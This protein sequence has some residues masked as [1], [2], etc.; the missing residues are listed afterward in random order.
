MSAYIVFAS[1][2]ERFIESATRDIAT[3]EMNHIYCFYFKDDKFYNRSKMNI[4]KLEVLSKKS[5]I[6]F[7]SIALKFD[8]YIGSWK[9]LEKAFDSMQL[10]G[11]TWLNISTMPRNMI[12]GMLHFLRAH[13]Y[14]V[15]YYPAKKHSEKPTTNP[16][17]PHIVLRHG[18]VMYPNKKTMLLVFIGYDRERIYQLHNYFEPYKTTLITIRNTGHYTVQPENYYCDFLDV[19]G[20]KSIELNSPSCQVAFDKLNEILTDEVL[21]KYNV[22]ICSLGPKI[23]SLGIYKFHQNHNEVALL[24]APSKDYADDYSTGIKLESVES[25]T[26]TWINENTAHPA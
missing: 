1:W 21:E 9:G 4:E 6:L 11:E 15:L 20:A 8:D 3:Q 13:P 7:N 5:D 12:F 14:K 18:G 17:E 22:L 26:S 25:I 24:Y 10:N 16:S 19:S 23:Q 2:E